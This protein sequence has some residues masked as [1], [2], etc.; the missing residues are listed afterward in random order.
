LEE[1]KGLIIEFG[2]PKPTE[3]L[4]LEKQAPVLC[5]Q[6]VE[7]IAVFLWISEGS[8]NAMRE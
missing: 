4:S 8:R 7:L 5:F 3:K 1:Y 6:A 2:C